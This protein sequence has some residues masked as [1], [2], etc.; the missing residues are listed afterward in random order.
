M[1][2]LNL[3]SAI[4]KIDIATRKTNTDKTVR[5]CW[6]SDQNAS[7]G[8]YVTARFDNHWSKTGVYEP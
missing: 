3:N 1:G 6:C 5:L 2:R 7:F 8:S 4:G